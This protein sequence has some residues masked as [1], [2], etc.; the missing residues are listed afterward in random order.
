MQH[1]RI[2][3]LSSARRLNRFIANATLPLWLR[4]NPHTCSSA[5]SF[6]TSP[7]AM[8]LLFAK[9]LSSTFSTPLS[10]FQYQ[11]LVSKSASMLTKCPSMYAL[12]IFDMLLFTLLPEP[13][14]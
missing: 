9:P 8:D 11:N 2:L 3:K 14:L 12:S 4:N 7:I 5:Y 13:R 6:L 1:V 10:T